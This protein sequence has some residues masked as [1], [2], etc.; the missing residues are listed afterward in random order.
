MIPIFSN[1]KQLFNLSLFPELPFSRFAPAPVKHNDEIEFKTKYHVKNV[2]R[3]SYLE[4]NISTCPIFFVKPSSSPLSWVN[5]PSL[6]MRFDQNFILSDFQANVFT[7]LI[8]PHFN[9]FSD[10]NTKN[11]VEM[12]KFTPLAKILHCRP[13]NVAAQ[14]A[15]WPNDPV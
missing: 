10:K 6:D 12:E 2:K 4:G 9:S 7:P 11:W 1:N 3:T 14:T 5:F 8:S 15:S 13:Q